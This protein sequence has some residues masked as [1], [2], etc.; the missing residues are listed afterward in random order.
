ML[1]TVFVVA[2]PEG[3]PMDVIIAPVYGVDKMKKEQHISVKHSDKSED[4]GNLNHAYTD[5]TGTLI[6]WEFI[7]K[8]MDIFFVLK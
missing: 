6:L 7:K 4:M 5:K 2:I 8:K 1:A 3:L